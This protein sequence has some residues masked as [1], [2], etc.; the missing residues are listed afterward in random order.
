MTS[1]E[2]GGAQVLLPAEVV[3]ELPRL[4][5]SALDDGRGQPCWAAGFQLGEAYDGSRCMAVLGH[6]A[7]GGT[8]GFVVPQAGVALAV[9]LSKLTPTGS[10]SRRLVEM[11][12][13]ELGLRLTMSNG[14]LQK[15]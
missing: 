9:T 2:I 12:L 3:T 10:A 1:V 13:D 8:V 6:G 4:R 15:A 14:L 11:L 7:V 5:R